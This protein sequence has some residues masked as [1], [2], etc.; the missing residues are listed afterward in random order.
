MNICEGR[1]CNVPIYFLEMH[2]SSFNAKECAKKLH[3]TAYPTVTFFST[4]VEVSEV[5]K[6]DRGDT[7]QVGQKRSARK[8]KKS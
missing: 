8:T 3:N 4:D 5:A 7:P 2:A 6:L 1:Y